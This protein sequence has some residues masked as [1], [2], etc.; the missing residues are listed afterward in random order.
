MGR[1]EEENLQ[2]KLTEK[3]RRD[4][5]MIK[6]NVIVVALQRISMVVALQSIVV[7]P[8]TTTEGNEMM[9]KIKVGTKKVEI[10]RQRRKEM[11]V[12]TTEKKKLQRGKK[13]TR[14]K[15]KQS[16]VRKEP[17]LIRVFSTIRKKEKLMKLVIAFG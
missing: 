2:R 1:G 4:V 5:R 6:I 16:V 11:K 3:K 14:R 9:R 7:L 15:W 12:K 8:K 13:M 10:P 17:P